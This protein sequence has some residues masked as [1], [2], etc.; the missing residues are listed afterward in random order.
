MKKFFL[1]LLIV[2]L[3]TFIYLKLQVLGDPNSSFN[4]TTRYNLGKYPIVRTILGL[5]SDG[6]ARE[7]YLSGNSSMAVEVVRSKNTTINEQVLNRFVEDVKTYTGRQVVLF[8]TEVFPGGTLS[9]SQL[10]DVVSGYRHHVV[11]GQPN[12]FV[13]YAEDYVRA[14]AEVGKTYHEFG[15]VLSDKRLREVTAQFPSALGQFQEST[16]LHEFGHQ[17]GLGHNEQPDCL[18]NAKA[19]QPSVQDSFSNIFTPTKFCDFELNQLNG[20]KAGIK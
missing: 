14:G 1:L 9:D 15:I 2:V 5:H 6:D 3:G 20:I 13:I 7:E 10:A 18:M 12:L 16:L 19:E 11:P 17:L 8:N 4:K